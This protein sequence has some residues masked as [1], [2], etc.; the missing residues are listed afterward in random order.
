[1]CC[2][3]PA[4]MCA[5]ARVSVCTRVSVYILCSQR[6]RLPPFV[7]QKSILK[8]KQKNSMRESINPSANSTQRSKPLAGQPLLRSLHPLAP[9]TNR[10]APGA[11]GPR[12]AGPEAS[13]AP[14]GRCFT[15]NNST[16]RL[17]K[18]VSKPFFFF[19]LFIPSAFT[20]FGGGRGVWIK[21][22]ILI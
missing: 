13:E 15:F 14:R 2:A 6:S 3:I 10:P 4:R 11:Q 22:E 17:C 1:M 7:M 5:C 16:V 18:N 20:Q 12:D 21:K 8:R 9:D 19:K